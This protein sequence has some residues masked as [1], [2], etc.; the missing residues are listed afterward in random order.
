MAPDQEPRAKV[1]GEEVVVGET[2][3]AVAEMYRQSRSA[4]W[5]LPRPRRHM[6]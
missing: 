6:R 3:E 5:T 4:E 1:A 2:A